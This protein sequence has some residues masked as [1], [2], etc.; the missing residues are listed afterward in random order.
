M[1]ISCRLRLLL[2]QVNVERAR[3]GQAGISLRQ[4][5]HESGVSLSVLTA[6]NMGRSHRIDYTTIDR[7]LGFFNGYLTVTTTD[8]LTWEPEPRAA[9]G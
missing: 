3:Q 7:L 2:A 6:L 8:L 5:A 1:T 9:A 4:L